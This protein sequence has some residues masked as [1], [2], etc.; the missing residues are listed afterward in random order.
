MV[1]PSHTTGRGG[2][3]S[4]APESLSLDAAGG[5]WMRTGMPHWVPRLILLVMVAY[6][7]TSWALV[8]VGHLSYFIH[9]VVYS[10]FVW[11]ALEP[12][13]NWLEKRGWRRGPAT[14]VTMLVALAL[15]LV[16]MISM[17]PLI[18]GEAQRLVDR[19]PSWVATVNPYL[20]RWFGIS[21]SLGGADAA[22]AFIKGHLSAW[23]GNI[24]AGVFGLAKGAVSLLFELL[25]I[26]M[27]SFYFVAEGPRIR[28][29]VCSLFRPAWQRAILQGW[30]ISIQ[31]MGGFLYSRGLLAIVIAIATF[32]VL[33]ILGV[34]YA[35]PLALWLAF[36]AEFIPNVGT[37]IGAVIPLAVCAIEKGV[38]A[39]IVLL[40]F[41]LVY[42]QFENYILSPHVSAHVMELHPAVAFGAAIVGG[43]LF[44]IMGAFLALPAVAII[45]AMASTY[46]HRHHLIDSDLLREPAPRDEGSS[47][48]STH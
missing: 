26:A 32:I 9:I 22:A 48:R 13:V 5:F 38:F 24:A 15:G 36:F 31:K 37:Y 28:R 17:V 44:G 46:I 21:I 27:F 19:L 33:K 41:I 7:A 11:L 6:A 43:S 10:L 18:L 39:F 20:Q 45:Q 35:L 34:P 30:D 4:P 16:I 14:G 25:T 1:E 29:G 47:G 8:Q 40:A 3:P 23:G 12:A 2:G 42:Q